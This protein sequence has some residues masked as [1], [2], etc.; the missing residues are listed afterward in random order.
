M[1]RNSLCGM[2]VIVLLSSHSGI[3]AGLGKLKK[4]KPPVTTLVAS[5]EILKDWSAKQT[6]TQPLPLTESLGERTIAVSSFDDAWLRGLLLLGQAGPL[7]QVSKE[8]GVIVSAVPFHATCYPESSHSATTIDALPLLYR[9]T[10]GTGGLKISAEWP[11]AML[12]TLAVGDCVGVAVNSDYV[13]LNA[14]QMLYFLELAMT[15]QDRWR[16][17]EKR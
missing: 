7:I 1:S 15:A 8:S 16:Y 5:D 14:G 4:K 11:A 13:R 2:L 9:F 6:A 10:Y 17:L 12:N 3:A